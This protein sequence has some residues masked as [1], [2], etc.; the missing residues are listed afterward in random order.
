M[1]FPK[2]CGILS[3]TR[4]HRSALTAPRLSDVLAKTLTALRAAGR[5]QFFTLP[6]CWELFGADFLVE[7]GTARA[8]RL[9]FFLGEIL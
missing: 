1:P 3:F 9:G 6:N 4:H 7:A 5:R 2:S 8:M